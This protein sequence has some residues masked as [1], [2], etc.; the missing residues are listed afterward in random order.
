MCEIAH[1]ARSPHRDLIHAAALK[2]L[3]SKTSLLARPVAPI[4]FSKAAPRSMGRP[5]I[6][7]LSFVG[8]LSRVDQDPASLAGYHSGQPIDAEM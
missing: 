1:Q 5:H 8:G 4:G 3:C 7:T 6:Q 2:S